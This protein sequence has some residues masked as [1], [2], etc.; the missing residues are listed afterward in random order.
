[1]ATF[2][3]ILIIITGIGVFFVMKK[4]SHTNKTYLVNFTIALLMA[5]LFI[6]SFMLVPLDWIG[7]IA[8]VFCGLAFIAQVILGVKNLKTS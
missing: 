1:M 5:L 6:R 4:F 8:I 3:S 2:L 7:Y